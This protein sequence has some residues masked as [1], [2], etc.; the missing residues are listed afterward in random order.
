[1]Q[2]GTSITPFLLGELGIGII[3]SVPGYLLFALFEVAAKQRG[4]LEVPQLYNDFYVVIQKKRPA[5]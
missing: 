4:A 5:Y 3:H 1:M 2:R